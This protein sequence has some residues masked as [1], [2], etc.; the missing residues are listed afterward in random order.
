MKVLYQYHHKQELIRIQLLGA[1]M[2]TAGN[3]YEKNNSEWGPRDP[4]YTLKKLNEA[5][6]DYDNCVGI[7]EERLYEAYFHIHLLTANDFPEA[8]QPRFKALVEAMTNRR[9]PT[10]FGTPGRIGDARNTLKGMH[11]EECQKILNLLTGLIV[12]VER[13]MGREA[14]RRK[15]PA[16]AQPSAG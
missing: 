13:S 11:P 14:E 4:S 12:E 10:P 3:R 5:L 8:M 2:A 15:S 16:Q 6:E 1:E 9:D 7:T